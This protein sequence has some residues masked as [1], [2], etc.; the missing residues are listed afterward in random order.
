MN[1]K[2]IYFG[3]NSFNKNIITD[4]Y[5]YEPSNHLTI[6]NKLINNDNF[7]QH[8]YVQKCIK[9]KLYSYKSQDLL[10]NKYNKEHFI[11]Y[12]DLLDKLLECK[13]LCYYC[14]KNINL[15]Y[16]RKRDLTQRTLERLDNNIGHTN[17]NTKISCLD[18]NLKRR[19]LNH[20]DYK[21]YKI[22]IV[23]KS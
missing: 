1:E 6:L 13:L 15:F 18:C 11:T 7:T 19:N 10:K 2:I 9:Q 22:I 3:N 23:K 17:Q 20:I 5:I 16:K 21:K 14:N 4:D 12:K 8:K